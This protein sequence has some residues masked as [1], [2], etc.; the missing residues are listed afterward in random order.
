M[1]PYM[2]LEILSQ[3]VQSGQHMQQIKIRIT[4]YHLYDNQSLETSEAEKD[5]GVMVDD[6]FNFSKHTQQ[7]INKAISKIHKIC[8]PT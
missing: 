5:I 2:A 1:V 6:Q 4:H 3:Q 7:K 8:S